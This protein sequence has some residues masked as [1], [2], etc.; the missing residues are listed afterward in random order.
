MGNVTSTLKSQF[1]IGEPLSILIMGGS[2][3]CGASN[4]NKIVNEVRYA[5]QL[6]LILSDILLSA[7]GRSRGLQSEL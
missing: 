1:V 3:S 7:V 2:I 4:N 5:R 6:E